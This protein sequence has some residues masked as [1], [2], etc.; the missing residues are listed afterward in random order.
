MTKDL[1]K[2]TWKKK[3]ILKEFLKINKA[4]DNTICN[5]S[6]CYKDEKNKCPIYFECKLLDIL[7]NSIEDKL[8]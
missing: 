3:H 2:E 8:K 1:K 6:Y 5:V 4:Y 7:L